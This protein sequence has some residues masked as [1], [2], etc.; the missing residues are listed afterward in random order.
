MTG[1]PTTDFGFRTVPATEKA[2]LV[3]QVFD[4]VAPRYDIMNDLMSL[5]VHRIWKRIFVRAIG[6]GPRHALLDLAAG[7]GDVGLLAREWGAGSVLLTDI[8]A[9]MLSRGRERALGRGRAA[10]VAFAVA[11][12]ER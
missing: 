9:D 2:G 8:N 7:T 4:S 6:A 1:E 11:D 12:A 3:R 5:G 10:G